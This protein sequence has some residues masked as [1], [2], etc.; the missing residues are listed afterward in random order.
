M[1]QATENY[2]VTNNKY[3]QQTATIT[4]LLD[5]DMLLL[6]TKINIITAKADAEN[7]YYKLLKGSGEL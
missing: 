2:R 4:D 5:A 3:T 6:Q 1:K 7:N